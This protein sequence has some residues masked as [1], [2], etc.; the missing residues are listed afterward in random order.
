MAQSLISLS[1]RA[2]HNVHCTLNIVNGKLTLYTLLYTLCK[3]HTAQRKLL[4]SYCTVHTAVQ[5]ICQ[6]CTLVSPGRRVPLSPGPRYSIH[7]TVYSVQY[8]LYSIHYTVYTMQYRDYTIQYTRYSIQTTHC[9]VHCSTAY[10]T[11]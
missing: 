7:Y 9:N 1:W 6:W 4:T 5:A 8:T 10:S 2:L 11:D 3:L